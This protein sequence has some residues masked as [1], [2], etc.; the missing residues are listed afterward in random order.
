MIGWKEGNGLLLFSLLCLPEFDPRFSLL[1]KSLGRQTDITVTYTSSEMT[2]LTHNTQSAEN[3]RLHHLELPLLLLFS[4][5][6]PHTPLQSPRPPT[7]HTTTTTTLTQPHRHSNLKLKVHR[8]LPFRP[9]GPLARAEPLESGNPLRARGLV[10]V[11]LC[12]PLALGLGRRR[13]QCFFCCRCC[14]CWVV[15]IARLR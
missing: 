15:P 8:V 3:T 9:L 11:L 6:L 1:V 13:E 7:S 12:S 14:C 2:V 5:L 4:P 10:L